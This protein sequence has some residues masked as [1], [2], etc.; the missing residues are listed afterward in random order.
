MR[1]NFVLLFQ[2]LQEHIVSF[3]KNELKRIHKVLSSDTSEC[4]ESQNEDEKLVD[5]GD[6]EQ[7]K[8]SREAF[9]K[10]TVHFLR[11]MKQEQLADRLQSSKRI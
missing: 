11:R 8:T 2:L 4:S 6:E 9:V 5:D 10:I 7:R 3:V 1:V